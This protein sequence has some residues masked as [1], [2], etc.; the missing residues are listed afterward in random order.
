MG[1]RCPS[2]VRG[3]AGRAAFAGRRHSMGQQRAFLGIA[4][5]W[6]CQIGDGRSV[7][8]SRGAGDIA[9]CQN[10][11]GAFETAKLIEKI[12]GRCLRWEIWRTTRSRWGNFKIVMAARGA[13]S[14]RG[15]GR[16]SA[17]MNTGIGVPR[18]ITNI[19]RAGRA[20]WQGVL[21]L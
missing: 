5:S 2:A 14:R 11:Q 6:K 19:G 16:R 10:P 15:R 8:G 18:L 9:G 3:S 12:P 7:G 13:N 1:W 21:Q 4:I 17:T 20:G